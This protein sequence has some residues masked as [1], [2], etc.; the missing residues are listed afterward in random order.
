MT[1]AH[2]LSF[3]PDTPPSRPATHAQ[4]A[5]RLLPVP[6][7]SVAAAALSAQAPKGAPATQDPADITLANGLGLV[8]L[9]LALHAA[10]VWA[11]WPGEDKPRTL[12]HKQDIELLRAL[13]EVKPEPPPPPV[14]RVDPPKAVQRPQPAPPAALRTAPAEAPQPNTMT[15]AENLTAPPTS[16][17]VVAAAPAP[18]PAPAPPPPAPPK[19]EPVTEPNGYAAFLNNPMPEYPRAAQRQGLRGKVVLRVFVLASGQVGQ[20]EVKQS[21]GKTLLDE[22]GQAAVKNWTFAP[23]KKG[24]TP[25]DAWTQ[26][27]FDFQPPA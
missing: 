4:A 22:A 13:P 18:A 3:S 12:V 27:T 24:K 1:T 20:V 11:V 7:V 5:L 14:K 16:G 25:V 26:V 21:S 19:E 10:A 23:A 2:A 8:G 6:P 15:V 9:A 17:P